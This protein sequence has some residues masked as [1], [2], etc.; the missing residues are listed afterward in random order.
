MTLLDSDFIVRCYQSYQAPLFAHTVHFPYQVRPLAHVKR[1]FAKFS[2][3][4]L[5][6]LVVLVTCLSSALGKPCRLEAAQHLLAA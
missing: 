6:L 4:L 3:C 2:L 5:S 1:R